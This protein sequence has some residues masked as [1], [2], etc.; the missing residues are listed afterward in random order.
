VK[1]DAEAEPG[2]A[3]RRKI[4]G[5]DL[6]GDRGAGGRIG[7]LGEQHQPPADALNEARLGRLCGLLQLLDAGGDG[8]MRGGVAEA[9]V[10]LGGADQ[11]REH[12]RRLAIGRR[13]G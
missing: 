10:E 4:A 13:G 1:A 2:V 12:H 3:G 7:A 11:L 8:V 5:R 9:G 6:H